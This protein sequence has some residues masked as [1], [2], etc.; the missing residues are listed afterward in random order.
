MAQTHEMIAR[1]AAEP[2]Q[3]G[4]LSK[5]TRIS[6]LRSPLPLT[7]IQGP[8][9][10]EFR[11]CLA[12]AGK[13]HHRAPGPPSFLHSFQRRSSCRPHFLQ[14]GVKSGTQKKTASAHGGR[15]PN[16]KSTEVSPQQ[17]HPPKERPPPEKSAPKAASPQSSCGPKGCD[18]RN[19]SAPPLWGQRSA[20]RL[21]GRS[22]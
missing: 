12:A 16:Q 10:Q 17:E 1:N 19:R 7:L 3:C 2:G 11:L 15:F 5:I 4:S 9:P 13:I 20:G 22:R 6:S 14:S 18:R 8:I 21:Q